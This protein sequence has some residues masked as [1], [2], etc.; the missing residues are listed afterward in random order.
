MGICG[1]K[2]AR[3]VPKDLNGQISNLGVHFFKCV[4]RLK[5]YIGGSAVCLVNNV[6]VQ[7]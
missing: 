4:F 1:H 6:Q 2:I 7:V 5:A 3:M